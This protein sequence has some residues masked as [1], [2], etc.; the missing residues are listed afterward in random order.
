MTCISIQQ[1]FTLAQVGALLAHHG[2]E[3][4]DFEVAKVVEV[5][6]RFLA[7]RDQAVVTDAEWA[8]IEAAHDAM[9]GQQGGDLDQDEC[10]R[11]GDAHQGSSTSGLRRNSRGRRSWAAAVISGSPVAGSKASRNRAWRSNTWFV[12]IHSGG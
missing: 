8:V 12:A 11:N 9:V 2:A 10:L 4:S 3:L 5:S 7:D 6:E 1:T